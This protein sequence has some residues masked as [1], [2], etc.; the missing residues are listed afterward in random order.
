MVDE[1]IISISIEKIPTAHTFCDRKEIC[2][3]KDEVADSKRKCR[4]K[5]DKKAE[6]DGIP[7]AALEVGGT[8]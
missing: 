8:T 2:G 5:V 3:A 4:G 6:R 7:E 1:I